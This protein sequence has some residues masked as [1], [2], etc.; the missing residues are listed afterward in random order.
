MK[1]FILIALLAS[2]TSCSSPPK[3]TNY[4][5]HSISVSTN[6]PTEIIFS[7]N[8]RI[9]SYPVE[10]E[11][12]RKGYVELF[13]IENKTQKISFW[14]E[15]TLLPYALSDYE[16]QLKL[17][18]Y[19]YE[20][21][22]FSDEFK[23]D[24]NY[25]FTSTPSFSFSN[26]TQLNNPIINLY[27]GVS[28]LQI[29]KN[30]LHSVLVMAYGLLAH[31]LVHVGVEQMDEQ[32]NTLF[33]EEY[34]AHKVGFCS[35]VMNNSPYLFMEFE[36]SYPNEIRND[37][38][39]NI[40]YRLKNREK[41]TSNLASTLVTYDLATYI[42]NDR[43]ISSKDEYSKAQKWCDTL[44]E[45]EM[46]NNYS[47]ITPKKY[48][49]LTN[50]LSNAIATSNIP[51]LDE[52]SKSGS[53]IANGMLNHLKQNVHESI[54]AFS[55]CST[56]SEGTL[57]QIYNC[58]VTNHSNYLHIEKK[59][60]SISVLEEL[61]IYLDNH[62]EKVLIKNVKTKIKQITSMTVNR[63]KPQ[64]KLVA[65]K[66]FKTKLAFNKKI[67]EFIIDTG[68]TINSSSQKNALELPTAVLSYSGKTVSDTPMMRLL[69]GDVET[70]F[71]QG[72]LDLIGWNYLNHF[73]EVSFG[74]PLDKFT[75]QYYFDSGKMFI[76]GDLK[77]KGELY[78]DINICLDTGAI[79]TSISANAFKKN[80]NM[81]T[82]L[83][84]KILIQ[85]EFGGLSKSVVKIL[86]E[87]SVHIGSELIVLKDTPVFLKESV[88]T[89][90]W[91]TLGITQ[92]EGFLIGID[93]QN[94]KVSL[95]SH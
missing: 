68:A 47:I 74:V 27:Q 25:Y 30:G 50:I 78:E 35:T 26:T 95:S 60:L 93:I 6:S 61:L 51:L 44:T 37:V 57:D 1:Y 32:V 7:S 13:T 71:V 42:G 16:R 10:S 39:A 88:A 22:F 8:S 4:F 24:I 33:E 12:N 52:F 90:C 63:I 34:L 62:N 64:G 81:L 59:E 75:Q 92:L 73:D 72:D 46:L 89:P 55:A 38:V 49:S 43:G 85:N 94:R 17:I 83:P 21:R 84:I 54:L 23:F 2:V 66:S 29:E 53:C 69:I 48:E 77:I 3:N 87:V 11:V 28:K 80:R 79:N 5:K 86:P 20:N 19:I 9:G 67:K 31:E 40:Q 70:D 91:I 45:H 58:A 76:Q 15:N 65:S 36:N 41:S 82:N 56:C 18:N 14:I